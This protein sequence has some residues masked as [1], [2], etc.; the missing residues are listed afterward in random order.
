MSPA[1]LHKIE[2]IIFS[3]EMSQFD[4]SK[5]LIEREKQYCM[6]STIRHGIFVV[7]ETAE[8]WWRESIDFG[9]DILKQIEKLKADPSVAIGFV[10]Q[11]RFNEPGGWHD[12]S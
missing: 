5:H 8:G 6:M 2:M 1:M 12:P 10:N 3:M 4:E 7:R 9:N 11:A